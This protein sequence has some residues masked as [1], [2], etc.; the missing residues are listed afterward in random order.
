MCRGRGEPDGCRLW[1]T[2][3]TRGLTSY[4]SAIPCNSALLRLSEQGILL[5]VIHHVI[6]NI[7]GLR[8]FEL[9]FDSPYIPEDKVLESVVCIR[10]TCIETPPRMTEHTQTEIEVFISAEV[11]DLLLATTLFAFYPVMDPYPWLFVPYPKI[12]DPDNLDSLAFCPWNHRNFKKLIRTLT[13]IPPTNTMAQ[14][15]SMK[16]KRHLEEKDP[17]AYPLLKW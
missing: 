6:Q 14:L 1:T 3:S 17:L 8:G 15:S 11:L 10:D 2:T 12:A 9:L 7:G 13:N 5:E 16:V 4:P